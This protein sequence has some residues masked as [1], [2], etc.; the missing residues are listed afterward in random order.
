MVPYNNDK[1]DLK[2]A[3]PRLSMEQPLWASFLDALRDFEHGLVDVPNFYDMITCIYF[4]DVAGSKDDVTSWMLMERILAM[5]INPERRA[6]LHLRH[7][8]YHPRIWT[9]CCIS[10]Q[11]FRCRTSTYHEGRS[12][13]E[14][15]ITLGGDIICCGRCG[16]HLVKGDGCDGITCVCGESFSFKNELL[17]K[18]N[19]IRFQETFPHQTSRMSVQVLCGSEMGNIA[20]AQAWRD[21]HKEECAQHYAQWWKETFYECPSQCAFLYSIKAS[22]FSEYFADAG[23]AE[24]QK[25]WTRF[26]ARA[27]WHCREQHRIAEVETNRCAQVFA[28]PNCRS[29]AHPISMSVEAKRTEAMQFLVLFGQHRVRLQQCEPNRP[30]VCVSHV[31]KGCSEIAPAVNTRESYQTTSLDNSFLLGFISSLRLNVYD[32][33]SLTDATGAMGVVVRDNDDGTYDIDWGTSVSTLHRASLKYVHSGIKLAPLI[34]MSAQQVRTFSSFLSYL[35]ILLSPTGGTA[36]AQD[37]L[38][39]QWQGN[40]AQNALA[41]AQLLRDV[42]RALH[43]PMYLDALCRMDDVLPNHGGDCL[44]WVDL[45]F[46]CGWAGEHARDLFE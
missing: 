2:I 23:V 4:V 41:E 22:L 33:V 45:Y 39:E 31:V 9:T 26:N 37:H 13:E 34:P 25:M 6:N 16:V 17:K 8:K 29:N 44:R 46:A 3:I 30:G 43:N 5:V 21:T 7:L 11:C 12:C 38:P 24:A 40:D 14:V 28:V 10:V 36:R 20:H 32:A 35:R 19:S 18:N 1:V 42:L 27:M 15:S